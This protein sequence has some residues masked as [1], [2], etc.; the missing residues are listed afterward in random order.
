MAEVVAPPDTEAA[1]VAYLLSAFSGRGETATVA[2]KMPRARPARMVRVQQ[3]D[4]DRTTRGHF[5]ARLLVECWAP[6]E[7]AAATLARLAYALTG[8][9][10]GEEIGGVFVADVVTV[11]GPANHPEPDVGP[12]YQFTVDLLVSGDT[13]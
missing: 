9:L 2:T 5:A 6:D 8:A 4:V 7:V 1:Y 3:V 10:E 11:G 13:I 12:R